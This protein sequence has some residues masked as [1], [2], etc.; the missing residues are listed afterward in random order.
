MRRMAPIA[1]PGAM[2]PA[3]KQGWLVLL[4]LA[5]VFPTAWCLVGGQMVWLLAAE[6]GADPPRAT[7]DID[8]VVDIRAEP[9]G[10]RDLCRWLEANDFD[11]EGISPEGIGHR[12]VRE[13]D[14]GPGRI[15]FDVLAMDH[16]GTRAD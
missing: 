16:A 2:P 12:Y 11:L 13:A 10:L 3:Q 8:L 6:H 5:R 7:V 15:M 9:T 14:P 1:L 4:N